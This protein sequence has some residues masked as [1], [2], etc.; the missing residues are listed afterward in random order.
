MRR[1]LQL[2]LLRPVT[3]MAN[4]FSSSPQRDK[5]HLALDNLLEEIT[6]NPGKHGEPIS[7][8]PASDKW[9]VFS[10]QHKGAKDG[11][12]DFMGCEKNYLAALDHYY[13]QGFRF[14]SLGDNEELWENTVAAVRKKNQASFKKEKL[15]LHRNSF[16]KIFGNHDLFWG[17]DPLA[18]WQLK[19][20]FGTELR[21]L[22]GLILHTRVNDQE[23]NIFL[24]HGHQGDA[25]SDGNWFS[26]WFVSN[27]WGPLQSYLRI[28][29]NTPACNEALKTAHN[30]IMYEWSA[31]KKSLILITGH[32]HQPVFE[33]LTH[34]ERLLKQLALARERADATEEKALLHEIA[35]RRTRGHQDSYESLE[36][37]RPSYFNTGCCCF[38]DGDITGI[39]IADGMIRLIKWTSQGNTSVR[40]VLEQRSLEDLASQLSA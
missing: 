31:A 34:L 10:D 1:F 32:T 8:D 4:K 11:A 20:I 19:R 27:V 39:E 33:S 21:I 28:N 13:Q 18:P 7:F 23:I 29:P 5:V 37:L 30:S 38:S 17:N 14:I 35:R 25:Q 15:F 36:K 6:S 16:F 24:T 22:E 40:M 9:I 26:K 3:W 2:I 12:D